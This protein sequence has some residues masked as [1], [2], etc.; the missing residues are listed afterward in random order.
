METVLD[1]RS[2]KMPKRYAN[3]A[4]WGK[5]TPQRII[6][7]VELAQQVDTSDEW[8][9]A[10]TGIRQ[11]RIVGSGEN[12]SQ[13]STDAS[14]TA[15]QRAGSQPHDL[16]LIIVATSN[17]DDITPPVS[18]LVHHALG[19]QVARVSALA[20]LLRLSAWL[21]WHAHKMVAPLLAL[22]A[23][24][25]LPFSVWPKRRRAGL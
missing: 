20:W 15:L 17:G 1:G 6:P 9:V 16:D 14:R 19:T 5:Y 13:M 12:N 10:R 7:N 21:Q 3:I 4:G 25:Y 2:K 22:L 11:R 24:L 23:V 18:S 8:I